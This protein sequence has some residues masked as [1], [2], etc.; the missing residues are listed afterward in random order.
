MDVELQY[1][2]TVIECGGQT[3]SQTLQAC[4]FIMCFTNTKILDINFTSFRFLSTVISLFYN[5]SILTTLFIILDVLAQLRRRFVSALYL[6]N[7]A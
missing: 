1:V 6:A 4:G 7:L 5:Y 3:T 2:L